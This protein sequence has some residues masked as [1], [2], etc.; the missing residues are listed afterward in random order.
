MLVL[1]GKLGSLCHHLCH[2]HR[3]HYSRTVRRVQS[4]LK[5]SLGRNTKQLLSSM[6]MN[7]LLLVPS[8]YQNC[9]KN[10]CPVRK[11]DVAA[12]IRP[13]I[14]SLPFHFSAQS[15]CALSEIVAVFEVIFLGFVLGVELIETYCLKI[16]LE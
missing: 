16:Y 13:I 3:H 7:L 4:I 1:L 12:A 11:S 6:E 8:S 15:F 5:L 14:A 9:P 10:I 2:H